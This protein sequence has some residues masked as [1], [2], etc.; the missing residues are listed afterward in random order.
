MA[1]PG[2][3]HRSLHDDYRIAEVL[4]SGG[5]SVVR[6]GVSWQDSSEVAIKTLK[7]QRQGQGHGESPAKKMKVAEHGPQVQVMSVSEALVA[8]EILVMRRIVEE[9]SPNPNVIQLLD[10]YE[11]G[12]GVH[13]VLEHCSGG[14]LFDR[15]VQQTRYSEAEAAAVVK[16]ICNG[17]HS[18]HNAHIVHRDLKPENC[19]FLT[20]QG[21]APLKI[22][23][24]GL[25]H[26]EE[27]TNPV[28]GM[29]GSIDYVAPESLQRKPVSPASDMWSV[30]VILYIL[31]CGYPPFHSRT[32]REKQEA[33]LAGRFDLTDDTWSTVSESAKDL[34]TSLLAVDPQKRPTA[35]ELLQHPWVS[36]GD[37]NP[38]PVEPLIFQRLQKFNA[39][40][41][42]RAAAIA[43]V[44]SSK[45]VGSM[46]TRN[47]HTLLGSQALLSTQELSN[48]HAHFKTI[49]GNG[50]G[51][52]LKEFEQV[53]KA[54]NMTRLVPLAPRIFDLFDNNRDGSVDMREIICGFS[55]L[56]KLDG[57]KALD[58]CFQMYDADGS[59]FISRDELAVML[60][61]L[62]EMYLPPDV[63]EPG[64]LDEIFDQMDADNDGRVS[65][66]EFKDAMKSNDGLRE[67]M[68]YPLRD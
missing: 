51:V 63:T 38:E 26:I 33:I 56:K 14:E 24:F 10:V 61:A 37:A 36:G 34:I 67:A 57:D 22:M 58:L 68:L 17:L 65:L 29:F 44:M 31:L 28:V 60:R 1:S 21:S 13:L 50:V 53:L 16:Q 48:L 40:R 39:R 6:K 64:K 66:D 41:K 12:A 9:V 4:G 2:P 52:S 62:P 43:S 19:L 3:E 47:L 25:S 59:G 5:F 42:F 54:M 20:R 30:G 55:S 8:N 23:D 32:T 15:I 49:S 11:D 46:R 45:L 27:L 35:A 7:K 18:L